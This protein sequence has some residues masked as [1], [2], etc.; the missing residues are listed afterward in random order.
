MSAT[1]NVNINLGLIVNRFHFLVALQNTAEQLTELV[2]LAAEV[3]PP[4][5]NLSSFKKHVEQRLD[6]IG[7][8]RCQAATAY[9]LIYNPYMDKEQQRATEDLIKSYKDPEGWPVYPFNEARST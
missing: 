8:E 2:E 1:S 4:H 5:Y 9:G 6:Q 3:F 7:Q